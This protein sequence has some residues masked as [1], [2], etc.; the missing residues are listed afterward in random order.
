MTLSYRVPLAVLAVLCVTLSCGNNAFEGCN[1][2]CT[3]AKKR[4][5]REGSYECVITALILIGGRSVPAQAESIE[6]TNAD[7][8]LGPV[9]PMNAAQQTDEAAFW[10]SRVG[11]PVL[12]MS[13]SY[14]EDGSDVTVNLAPTNLA[15]TIE[16]QSITMHLTST[17]STQ[18]SGTIQYVENGNT[19]EGDVTIERYPDQ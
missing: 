4:L 9:E 18:A 10:A 7:L 15:A 13:G 12:I 19:Y 5:L 8:R 14:T 16:P 17:S 11:G 2:G 6:I 1:D 3:D